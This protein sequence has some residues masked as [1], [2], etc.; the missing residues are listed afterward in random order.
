MTTHPI[1]SMS[2]GAHGQIRREPSRGQGPRRLVRANPGLRPPATLSRGERDRAFRFRWWMP[3]L[4]AFALAAGLVLWVATSEAG[5]WLEVHGAGWWALTTILHLP[6][7]LILLFLYSDCTWRHCC[8]GIG[9][10]R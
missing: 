1:T 3:Q 4:G 5:G 2:H 6:F 7:F 8:S 10:R 9:P